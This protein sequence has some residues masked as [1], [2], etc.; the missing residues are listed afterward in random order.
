MTM[1]NYQ[2]MTSY[3]GGNPRDAN[4]PAFLDLRRLTT[5]LREGLR[6]IIVTMILLA[7]AAVLVA[8]LLPSTYVSSTRILIDP[9]GLRVVDNE[10]TPP[11]QTADANTAIVESQMRVM[12][13]DSVLRRV[14]LQEGLASDPEFVG[15]GGLGSAIRDMLGL[16]ASGPTEAP[17]VQALRVLWDSVSVWRAPDSYVV[18]I[19]VRTEDPHKSARLASAIADIYVNSEIEQRGDT[20][21][22]ASAALFGRLDELRAN[23]ARAE[24][25]VES[26]RAE[27]R[28]VDADGA[29]INEQQVSQLRAELTRAEVE[30]SRAEERYRQIRSITGSGASIDSLPEALL[31]ST[32]SRLREA[33]VATVR[34][35]RS[36]SRELMDRHPSLIRAR[37]Q[38]AALRAQIDDELGRIAVSA[39]QELDR[40]RQNLAQLTAM[41]QTSE[42]TT[43]DTK[44]ALVQLRELQR[45]AQASRMVYESYL[46][47]AREI[48]EQQGLNTTS[49]RIISPALAPVKPRGL[50]L[51]AVL[52]LAL[53]AGAGLGAVLALTRAAMD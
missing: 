29:L 31:S 18:D 25:A 37:E 5:T 1:A 22:S 41:L 15:R 27:N 35:E 50:S 2:D 40:A 20:A 48:D 23:L 14:V 21:R 39:G 30:A 3:R 43:L 46:V 6:L 36:L 53:A 24:E 33:Y 49:A 10:V 19:S 16:S 11:S 42:N 12:I 7:T 34:E 8:A 28:I 51:S 4:G 38:V 45:E 13:S 44:Q 47:R 26:Y 17:E 9:R 32:I 52:V